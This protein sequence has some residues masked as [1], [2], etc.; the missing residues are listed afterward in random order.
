MPPMSRD[1][2]MHQQNVANFKARLVNS[3]DDA[4]RKVI[5]ELLAEEMRREE[6]RLRGLP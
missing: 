2:F 5:R 1:A 6:E 4:Q 3:V